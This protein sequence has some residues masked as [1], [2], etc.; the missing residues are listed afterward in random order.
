MQYIP[1]LEQ[2]HEDARIYHVVQQYSKGKTM[3]QI[4][5]EMGCSRSTIQKYLKPY[6]PTEAEIRKMM[7]E[8]CKETQRVQGHA[9]KS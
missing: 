9:E 8:K 1:T 3:P 2:S 7:V 4:A 6:R 5:D